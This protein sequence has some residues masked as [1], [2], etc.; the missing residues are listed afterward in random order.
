MPSLENY[1]QKI[2][3]KLNN[4]GLETRKVKKYLQ[5]LDRLQI[6]LDVLKVS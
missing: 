3:K 6:T 5:E 4:E 2:H 1:V